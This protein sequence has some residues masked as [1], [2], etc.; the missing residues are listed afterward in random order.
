MDNGLAIKCTILG[1]EEEGY[2]V[3]FSYADTEDRNIEYDIN[4]DKDED[5]EN[6]F[7]NL[8][9]DFIN[10]F[11]DQTQQL[12]KSKRNY[13]E[14]YISEL[15]KRIKE[16]NEENKSLKTDMSILQKRVD[17]AQENVKSLLNS[18]VW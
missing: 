14:T 10:D 9:E 4:V 13:N 11:N 12:E 18:F 6:I 16:L 15:E 8:T 1:D 3:N 2:K 17:T 7:W 5:L